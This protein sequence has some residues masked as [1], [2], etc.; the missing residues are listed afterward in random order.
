MDL[1]YLKHRDQKSTKIHPN[2]IDRLVQNQSALPIREGSGCFYLI[3]GFPLLIGSA[4]VLPVA[5]EGQDS[6]SDHE[7]LVWCTQSLD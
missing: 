4:H 6:E 2:L 1:S 5:L 7:G 3:T